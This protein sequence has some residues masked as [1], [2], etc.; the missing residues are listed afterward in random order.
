MVELR[1]LIVV[2][3]TVRVG[4]GETNTVQET[5]G[6]STKLTVVTKREVSPD[7]RAANVITTDYMRRLRQIGL[8]RT[9]FGVLFSVKQLPDVK[10]LQ[11]D[12]GKKIAEY[13]QGCV[14]RR[15]CKLSNCVIWETLQG[16]RAVAVAAWIE[17]RIAAKDPAV[18]RV[19]SEIVKSSLKVA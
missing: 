17:E 2:T 4:G 16:A 5:S 18:R 12:A 13:N 7:R 15:V 14:R 10:Q 8:L 11:I 1:P 9:P 3:G 19:L 6:T